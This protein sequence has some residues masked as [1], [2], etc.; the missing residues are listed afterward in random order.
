[1]IS[2]FSI[3]KIIIRFKE[4]MIPLNLLLN[5]IINYVINY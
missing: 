4:S 3:V 1:M 2:I 5:L